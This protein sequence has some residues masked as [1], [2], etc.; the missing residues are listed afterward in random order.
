[1][2]ALSIILPIVGI[3]F[4]A[5]L[6]LSGT[7]ATSLSGAP[8]I[9]AELLG[10]AAVAVTGKPGYL[11][12]RNQVFSFLKQYGPHPKRSA[13]LAT[14]LDWCCFAFR[15]SLVGCLRISP[16]RYPVSCKTH[17]HM[18]SEETSSFL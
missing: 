12:I 1:M 18:L 5:S 16:A 6:G 15:S 10:V 17:S 14:T 2:F 11:Y 9:G 13:G 8:L 3:P 4:V 7:M